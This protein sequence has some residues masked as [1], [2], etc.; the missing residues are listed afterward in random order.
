VKGVDKNF[1]A[2]VRGEPHDGTGSPLTIAGP[3]R[4]SANSKP[5]ENVR[6]AAG[7]GAGLEQSPWRITRQNFVAKLKVP[8]T[9]QMPRGGNGKAREELF[10]PPKTKTQ[11]PE[12]GDEGAVGSWLCAG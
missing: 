5:I 9:G 12:K 6:S 7:T 11:G 4:C 2:A 1:A 8:K 3:A 10:Q